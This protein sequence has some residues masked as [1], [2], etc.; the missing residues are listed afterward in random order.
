[1]ILS[2]VNTKGGVGK[3]T[4]SVHA[5]A[6][7]AEQ[8]LR[9]ALVD[10][11]EQ[12]SSS[13]WLEAAAPAIPRFMPTGAAEILAILPALSARFDVIVAD[14]PAALGAEVAA[15]IGLADV[16]VMPLLPSTLDIWAS[17]KTARLI[18]KTQ[19]HPKRGGLPHALV[20][21]NRA[22]SRTRLAR[23]A[24]EAV[25]K[26]GFPVC[27]VVLEARTAYAEAC[28][29]GTT[30][31]R[32]GAAGVRAGV[33]TARVIEHMLAAAPEFEAG[34]ALLSRRAEAAVVAKKSRPAE[35]LLAPAPGA[36]APRESVGAVA[37][38]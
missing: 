26:Y 29:R 31:W 25:Q 22:Q 19:F 12:R 20:V 11:D 30:V 37:D 28:A 14:G 13:R 1:M 2:I 32:L 18:Y 10:A 21:I 3:S 23:I 7:L 9:V 34:Q 5:A 4:I 36:A 38:D 24:A 35:G 6:W 17:F 27:P 15:L 8:G 16:A 33:E